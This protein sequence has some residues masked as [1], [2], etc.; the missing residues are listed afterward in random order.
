MPRE[1][2]VNICNNKTMP[3]IC[4]VAPTAYPLISKDPTH[5]FIGGAELQQIILARTL[6]KRGY[7]VSM[8][9]M[10]HG[11][12][13]QIV[14]DGITIYRAYRPNEGIPILR[15]IYPRLTSVWAQMKKANADIYYQRSAGMLTGIVAKFCKKYKKKSIYAGASNDDFLKKTPKIKYRRDSIL[16]EYGIRNVNQIIV[17]NQTQKTLLESNYGV[18]SVIIPSG[19]TQPGFSCNNKSGYI[20]WVANIRKVKRPQ[21]IIAL[22][23]R[24]PMYQFKM[25]GGPTPGEE[26]LYKQI[27]HKAQQQN[28]VEFIGFVPIVEVEKHFDG[29][30]IVINTSESEGFPNTFLQAWSRMIPTVS[31]IDCGAY[32]S[33]GT[34]ISDRV[35]TL[36]KMQAVI[37]ELMQN[38]QIWLKKGSKANAYCMEMHSIDSVVSRLIN[39]IEDIH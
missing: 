16:F 25:V 8:I 23:K 1:I 38:N 18:N 4:F 13:D 12:Q 14:V 39:I 32:A 27:E 36:D 35:N 34:E 31:F 33:D 9:C 19:H 10:D 37:E 26:A 21:L 24:L 17:Q 28:N 30:R 15:F 3:A 6:V 2:F 11:Q 22:A 29:A 5:N 20:L 7:K